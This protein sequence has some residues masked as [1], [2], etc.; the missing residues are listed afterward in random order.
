MT[1]IYI[2]ILAGILGTVAMTLCTEIA[3][4]LL[5]RPYHVVR[6]LARMLQGRSIPSDGTLR[7]GTYLLASFLHYAIG[8]AFSFGYQWLVFRNILSPGV[9]PALLFGAFI[10]LIGITGWRIFFAIH[11]LPPNVSL[12]QYLPA[13]WVGHIVLAFVMYYTYQQ[14]RNESLTAVDTIPLC[15]CQNQK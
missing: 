5:K 12:K 9:F 1:K 15:Y 11:P 2:P 3:F 8:V 7:P 14:F 6:I 13:I 4:R 10:G